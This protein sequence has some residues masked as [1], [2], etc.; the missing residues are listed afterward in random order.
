MRNI[1]DYIGKK[2]AVKCDNAEQWNK[3]KELC[4][5]VLAIDSD[6]TFEYDYFDLCVVGR[7]IT[8]EQM[9]IILNDY[10]IPHCTD[11]FPSEIEQETPEIPELVGIEMY[12]SNCGDNWRKDYVLGTYK[13][14]IIGSKGVWDEAV[15][16]QPKTIELTLEE[17]TTKL[18]EQLGVD[19]VTIKTK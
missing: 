7:K 3:M 12:V 19:K 2:Y 9:R 5:D 6:F 10:T 18:A 11:F 4:K 1:K 13:G 8:Y 14:K 17:A 16:I 15:P